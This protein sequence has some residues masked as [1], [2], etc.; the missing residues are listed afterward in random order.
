MPRR[1]TGFFSIRTLVVALEIT[2]VGALLLVWLL[3]DAARESKSLWILFLYSFPSEFLVAPVPHEP[4]FFYFGKFYPAWLVAG[5]AV[6]S[7]VMTEALNYS[8]FGYFTDLESFN[9]VHASRITRRVVDLFHKAP[10]VAV[11]VAGLLPIPFYPMRFIV[12]LARY[13]LG[14]YLLA[15][16]VSRAPRFYV[17]SLLGSAFELPTWLL[18]VL[19][20]VLILA[21]N[22]PLVLRFAGKKAD[23]GPD[24]ADRQ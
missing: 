10:F 20:S 6:T 22:V 4:I 24:G 14:R 11:V 17:L 9:R 2:F 7:T 13:P 12:V 21:A 5:I 1:P 18:V 8:V 23:G 15:V 19:F 16:L 3:S